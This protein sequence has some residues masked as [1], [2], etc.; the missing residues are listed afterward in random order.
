MTYSHSIPE[1]TQRIV[2]LLNE[3]KDVLGIKRVYYGDQDKIEAYPSVGVESFPKARSLA[4]Q[5]AG[6]H[7]FQIDLSCGIYIYHGMLQASYTTKK[8]TDEFAELV[9][10]MIHSD[11][12]LGGLVIFGFVTRVEPGV[13][14]KSDVMVKT[15]RLTWEGQSRQ[16]F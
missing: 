4:A 5:G 12:T 9:E 13:A 11:F 8:E 15:T 14:L 10:D 1:I 3:Q 2:D 16:V 6:L 7:K